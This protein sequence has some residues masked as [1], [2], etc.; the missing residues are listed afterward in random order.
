MQRKPRFEFFIFLR[1]SSVS[2]VCYLSPTK[3]FAWKNTENV[4]WEKI[5]ET[6]IS[7]KKILEQFS[8]LT[9]LVRAWKTT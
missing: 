7:I 3:S 6:L 8:W 1:V 5:E 4:I 2:V 9:F